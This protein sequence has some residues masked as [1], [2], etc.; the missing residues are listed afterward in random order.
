ME[1]SPLYIGQLSKLS[2]VPIKTIRY[3]EDLGILIKPKRTTSQYRSYTRNDVD[4]LLF[5]KKAKELGLSLAEIKSIL[6]TSG[7]GVRPCCD[8]VKRIF[9]QKIKEYEEKIADL[10]ATKTKLE[11]RLRS[12]I[13]PTQAK[14]IKYTI[15]PHIEKG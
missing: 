13:T 11:K 8:Y 3:Y 15:C 1:Q 4:K 9:N 10:A 2:G 12:W 7:Q 5:I 6:I 14:K